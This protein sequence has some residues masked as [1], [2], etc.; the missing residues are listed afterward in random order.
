M[1]GAIQVA[2]FLLGALL[3]VTFAVRA[4]ALDPR[5][6]I[7]R[8]DYDVCQTGQGLPQAPV[9]SIAQTPDDYLWRRTYPTLTALVV[10]RYI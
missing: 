8:Y 9:M 2:R 4:D 1:S 7:S 10:K 3:R 6:A 5:K